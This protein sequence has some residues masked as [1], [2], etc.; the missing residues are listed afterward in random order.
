HGIDIDPRAVQIAAAAL[1]LKAKLLAPRVTVGRMNLVAPCFKLAKL[2]DSDPSRQRLEQELDREVGIPKQL[3]AQLID[4]LEGVDHLGTLLRVDRTVEQAL[5]EYDEKTR[6]VPP[7]GEL[8]KK[9]RDQPL[10]LPV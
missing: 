1:W 9:R 8:F 3:T 5:R 7:Q 10:K 2:P 6:S 4:S